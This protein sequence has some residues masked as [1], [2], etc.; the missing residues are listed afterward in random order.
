[1]DD[2]YMTHGLGLQGFAWKTYRQLKL[3]CY[4]GVKCSHLFLEPLPLSSFIPPKHLF[5]QMI[6]CTVG[7]EI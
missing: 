7:G 6:M 1:M 5:C 3:K 4:F 2:P